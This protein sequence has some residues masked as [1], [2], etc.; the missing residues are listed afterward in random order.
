MSCNERFSISFYAFAFASAWF[1]WNSVSTLQNFLLGKMNS[2]QSLSSNFF[3]YSPEFI[4]GNYDKEAV[5]YNFNYVTSLLVILTTACLSIYAAT[6]SLYIY[7]HHSDN[8][9][10][11]PDQEKI[12]LK[13]EFVAKVDENGITEMAL[14]R[15]KWE[16]L[17]TLGKG[18]TFIGKGTAYRCNF[19]DECGFLGFIN[20]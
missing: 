6:N 19:T 5:I 2:N 14:S 8:S 16:E 9:L 17:Q 1:A 4:Y 10:S 3:Y 18:E 15:K 12:T 7:M 11:V 13:G 20:V